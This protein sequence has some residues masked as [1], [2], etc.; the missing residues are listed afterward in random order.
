MTETTD[1]PDEPETTVGPFPDPL[2]GT[3]PPEPDTP[4]E[5]STTESEDE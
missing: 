2:P 3:E 5:P 4:A 1:T